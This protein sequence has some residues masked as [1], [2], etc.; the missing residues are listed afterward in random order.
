MLFG[1]DDEVGVLRAAV[2]KSL[3]GQPQEAVL[4]EGASGVGKTALVEGAHL[5]T[6]GVLVATFACST[7]V[8]TLAERQV[9]MG[10]AEQLLLLADA[11]MPGTAEDAAGVGRALRSA[12]VRVEPAIVVLD[13]A[14]W[15]DAES[16]DALSFAVRRLMPA[17]C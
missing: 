6:S 7:R 17:G 8:A 15:A 13:D 14:H 11:A 10:V 2:V 9:A 4:I 3:G 5:R 16:L 12:I 1:R